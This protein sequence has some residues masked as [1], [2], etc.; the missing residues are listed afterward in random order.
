MALL[1]ALAVGWQ[2]QPQR[3][4][5][6]W[7]LNDVEKPDVTL[8]VDGDA[9]WMPVAAL[10]QAGLRHG[11]GRRDTFF[12]EPFVLLASLAPSITYRL[13]TDDVRL[14]VTAAPELLPATT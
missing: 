14:L 10:T 3:S 5:W 12:G 11:G 13:D 6:A 4:I 9:V 8:I 7:T 1:L 2:A